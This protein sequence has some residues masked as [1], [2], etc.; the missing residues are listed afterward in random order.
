VV[1]NGR[2]YRRPE[3]VATRSLTAW[4][5]VWIPALVVGTDGGRWYLAA[6]M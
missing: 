4:A 5:P 3:T 2:R 1:R 6:K